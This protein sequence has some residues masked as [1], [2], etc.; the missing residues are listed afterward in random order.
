MPVRAVRR[1]QNPDEVSK[2]AGV[3]ELSREFVL[4]GD[5]RSGSDVLQAMTGPRPGRRLSW[6]NGGPARAW[7]RTWLDTFDWRL[8]RA[9]LRSSRSAAATAPSWC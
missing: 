7:R 1:V 8:Y 3:A 2:V 9:G 6:V 5:P 4:D